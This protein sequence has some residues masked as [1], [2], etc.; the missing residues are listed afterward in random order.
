MPFD[1]LHDH[2]LYLA[3]V[4]QGQGEIEAA[5][6]VAQFNAMPEDVQDA[7]TYLLAR[8]LELMAHIHVDEALAAELR[9]KYPNVE[10]KC[11][12]I[13]LGDGFKYVII[14]ALSLYRNQLFD[15]LQRGGN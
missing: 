9:E 3:L 11:F 15:D 8:N 13:A 7:I 14:H 12:D 5:K 1:D 6:I 10:P 4:E 2:A